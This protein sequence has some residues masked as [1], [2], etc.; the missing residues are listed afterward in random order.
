MDR[1]AFLKKI[2]RI[3]DLPTLPIVAV[4]VNEMIQDENVSIKQLSETITKDQAMVSK[5]L[6]LVNS[7]FYGFRSQI[8]TVPHA[9]TILGF[10][11]VRNAVVS[12]SV[13]EALSGQ[14]VFEGFDITNF[15][16]HSVGVAVT[17]RHLAEKTRLTTPDEAFVAGILHDVGK[18]LLAQYFKDLFG[19]VW[20]RVRDEGLSFN[21]AE[22]KLLPVNH[23]QIGGHL[24][25]KWQL[26]ASLVEVISYHHA[27]NSSL[28]N[29][30][31]LMVVHTS[32]YIVNNYKSDSPDGLDP[33]GFYPKAAEMMAPQLEGL[34]D[35]FPAVATEIEAACGFFVEEG[36]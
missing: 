4:K 20:A 33:S 18:V 35:W 10:S 11:T 27:V 16:R 31:L 5:L 25:R 36:R 19:Q 26:P 29:L 24:A 8:N 32:N 9:I 17:G 21:E 7:A 13:I 34:T 14:D 15:W 30:N 2:D 22:N 1:E 3:P 23:G 28:V 12:V 6:K